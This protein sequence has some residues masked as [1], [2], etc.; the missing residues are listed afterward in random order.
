MSLILHGVPL[1]PFVRKVRI[2]LAEKQLSY[3]MQTVIP[4]ATREDY[5]NINPLR[6]IPALQDGDVIICDSAVICDYLETEQPR[7]PLYPA[8]PAD[9]ARCLWLEKYADYELAPASTF[10]VFFQHIVQPTLGNQADND[11][12]RDA[13]THR[14]PPHLDYLENQL[15]TQQWFVNNQFSLADIAIASQLVNLQHAGYQLDD[16][17]WP[18]LSQHLQR[19][20]ARD[21]VA[22]MLASEQEMVEKIKSRFE[23]GPLPAV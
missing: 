14:I 4:Y 1:S 13:I 12:I 3:T 18:A 8:Q 7:T 22:S 19:F 15:G 5:V 10:R 11:T 23:I 2:A 9:R 16:Q 17:R 21:S 20:C 6:R